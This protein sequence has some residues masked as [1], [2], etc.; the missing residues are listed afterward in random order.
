MKMIIQ[1][2]YNM[3]MTHVIKLIST[4]TYKEKNN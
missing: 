3:K 4:H 1:H 2:R